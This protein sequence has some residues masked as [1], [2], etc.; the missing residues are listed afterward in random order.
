MEEE[1]KAVEANGEE[2][3]RNIYNKPSNSSSPVLEL[4][5][6][7]QAKVEAEEE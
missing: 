4:W 6:R 7:A 2:E 1:A 5:A 3:R